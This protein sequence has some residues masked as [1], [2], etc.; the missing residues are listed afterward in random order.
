MPSPTTSGKR[1]H[2]N[3]CNSQSNEYQG[4]RLEVDAGIDATWTVDAMASGQ[5]L[6]DI[7]HQV[8]V[9]DVSL[10]QHPPNLFLAYL[11]VSRRYFQLKRACCGI[12]LP[13]LDPHYHEDYYYEEENPPC[14]T[15]AELRTHRPDEYQ[16][17]LEAT[18]RMRERA[19]RSEDYMWP[20]WRWAG[21]FL[22]IGEEFCWKNIMKRRVREKIEREQKAREARLRA[23]HVAQELG[24]MRREGVVNMEE[25][26]Q[27]MRSIGYRNCPHPQMVSESQGSGRVR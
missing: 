19:G 18:R 2:H 11:Q 14:W 17:F 8:A 24:R 26:A 7:L 10:V 16:E 5:E 9:E 6:E 4:K 15:A 20:R 21:C 12:N 22:V 25:H 27:R 23:L 13:Y 3:S 1:G